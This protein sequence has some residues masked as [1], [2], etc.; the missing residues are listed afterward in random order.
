MPSLI[1]LFG[2]NVF[3]NLF[4]IDGW[5]PRISVNDGEEHIIKIDTIGFKEVLLQVFSTPRN[6]GCF[7]LLLKLSQMV[8]CIAHQLKL[9]FVLLYEFFSFQIRVLFMHFHAQKYHDPRLGPRMGGQMIKSLGQQLDILLVARNDEG[10]QYFLLKLML[11]WNFFLQF[12][13]LVQQF[14]AF[15]ECDDCNDDHDG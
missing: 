12:F 15:K 4:K 6:V 14:M 9:I 2:D 5:A 1:I 11:D 10:M 8:L 13:S 3:V 7:S